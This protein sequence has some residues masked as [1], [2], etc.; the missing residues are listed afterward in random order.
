MGQRYQAISK[1]CFSFVSKLFLGSQ[2]VETFPFFVEAEEGGMRRR[3][4]CLLQL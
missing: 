1:V 2:N 4:Q 3:K